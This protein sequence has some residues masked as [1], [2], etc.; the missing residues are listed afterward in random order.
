MLA[1]SAAEL[2]SIQSELNSLLDKTGQIYAHSMSKDAYG[3]PVN[4][5]TA[6][7]SVACGMRQPSGGELQNFDYMI[8]DKAAWTVH[9]PIG[10]VFNEQDHIVIEG[11]TLE[12]HIQL[13]PKSYPGYLNVICAEI[14]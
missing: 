10:T 2:A 5:W 8:G 9:L 6:G 3:T 14:K 13:T 11:Q 7:A 4:T 1:V 12:A